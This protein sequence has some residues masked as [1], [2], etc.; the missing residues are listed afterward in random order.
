MA[1][2]NQLAAIFVSG[3]SVL[4]L[5]HVERCGCE[6]AT[7]DFSPPRNDFNISACSTWNGEK[8]LGG[9]YCGCEA[10]SVV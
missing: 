6:I 4:F 3:L 2:T 7:S 1:A 10:S 5:F 9:I 8:N